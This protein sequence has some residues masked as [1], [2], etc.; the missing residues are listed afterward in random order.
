MK[1][2]NE[3]EKF[4]F[5]DGKNYISRPGWTNYA[6]TFGNTP[7]LQT[8]RYKDRKAFFDLFD[9]F[10]KTISIL[11][12]GCSCGINLRILKEL[13]FKNLTGIDISQAACQDAKKN[14][15]DLNIVHGSILE[16]PFDDN[17]FDVVFTMGVL[18]H[19]KPT[20]SLPIAM[21]EAV[22]CS[23]KT[24]LG[25]EDY[26]PKFINPACAVYKKEMYWR[27][28]FTSAWLEHEPSLK[29]VTVV[30]V[31]M[32]RLNKRWRQSYRLEK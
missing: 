8:N 28:P 24:I 22:R 30:N 3:Q 1:L 31:P 17:Q 9:S 29:V 26:A 7:P 21:K 18:I 20:V 12:M 19:Q 5:G 23:K 32:P 6:W 25:F 14:H 27:G 13:G 11:E 15:P 4:W 10:P 16:M 2:K